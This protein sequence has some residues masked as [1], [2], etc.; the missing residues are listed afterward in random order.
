MLEPAIA[1]KQE[2]QQKFAKE[3]YS[4]RWFLYSS[5]A[6]SHNIPEITDDDNWYIYAVLDKTE[7]V[8]YFSYYIDPLTNCAS[9]FALY[10]FKP[11]NLR[12]VIDIFAK[13]EQLVKV[14]HRLEWSVVE[15]NP[16]ERAYDKFCKKHNGRKFI[17]R[18]ALK[19]PS[20]NYRNECIYEI[21]TGDSNAESWEPCKSSKF[22]NASREKE[23]N[24]VIESL[25][26]S[27]RR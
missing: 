23:M 3:I 15:G 25:Q 27:S 22:S 19:D 11:G 26:N 10:S 8:G 9:R 12:V 16:A 24:A 21:V 6:G 17:F 2:L 13:L 5:R 18:D 14:C 7:V 20:G 1:H 4:D